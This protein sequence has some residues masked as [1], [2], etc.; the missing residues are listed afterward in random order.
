MTLDEFIK[1]YYKTGRE[2]CEDFD[3]TEQ[4]L[5]NWHKKTP[6][7]IFKIIRLVNV[8]KLLEKELISEK[9]YNKVLE[10]KLT[11]MEKK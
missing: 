11:Q 7:F 1:T 8:N 4:T 6:M 9:A 10:L 5:I 3:I 2:F